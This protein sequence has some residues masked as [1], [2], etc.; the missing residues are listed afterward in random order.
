MGGADSADAEV[1][2]RVSRC[3][4]RTLG[5]VRSRRAGQ[6]KE[7]N[8]SHILQHASWRRPCG[9]VSKKTRVWRVQDSQIP[10]THEM[11]FVGSNDRLFLVSPESSAAYSVLL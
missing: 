7:M 2:P 11:P 5:S 4:A 8:K 6:R 10:E 1:T 3:R 9:A